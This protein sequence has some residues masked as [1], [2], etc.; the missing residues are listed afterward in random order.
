MKSDKNSGDLLFKLRKYSKSDAIMC[1]K[2][3]SLLKEFWRKWSNLS[4]RSRRFWKKKGVW[5]IKTV[6]KLLRN[7][8]RFLEMTRRILKWRLILIHWCPRKAEEAAGRLI[9][10][11][12]GSYLQ[13][14]LNMQLQHELEKTFAKKQSKRIISDKIRFWTSYMIS[15]L[16]VKKYNI[17]IKSKSYNF[18]RTECVLCQ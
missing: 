18:T 15:L 12:A 2:I 6:P 10:P 3:L 8:R 4:F 17:K 11:T 9:A 7:S 13:P 16:C 5:Y 1:L 14:V